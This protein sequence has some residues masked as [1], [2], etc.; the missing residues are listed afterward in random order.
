M[1]SLLRQNLQEDERMAAWVD[2]HV[3]D[4]T[5]EFLRRQERQAA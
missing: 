5:L 3:D 1:E 4:I 2:E